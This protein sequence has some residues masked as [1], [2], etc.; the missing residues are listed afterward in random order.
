MKRAALYIRVSTDE[1]A[2]HGYSLDEQ[3][4]TL[5]DYAAR[6]GYTIVDIYA[7]EGA[8]ARKALKNR[9]ELQRLLADVRAGLIDCILFIKLDRWFRNIRDFYTV[10]DILDQHG[11]K[12]IATQEDY[13]TTTSAGRLNLNIRLSIAQNESDQTGERIRFIFDGKRRRH[14]AIAGHVTFG[15]RVED[16]HYVIDEPQ[17][18][19]VRAAFLYYAT[20]QS[21]YATHKHINETYDQAFKVESIR[22]MLSNERYIGRFWG[23][24]DYAPAV[25]DFDLWEKV[26]KIRAIGRRAEVPRVP[27]EPYLFSGLLFCPVCGR[28]LAGLHPKNKKYYRCNYSAREHVCTFS[29][30]VFEPTVERYL[31]DN[32]EER[33]SRYTAY[34]EVLHNHTDQKAVHRRIT[35]AQSRLDR[36]KD[37]YVTGCIDRASYD[38]DFKVYQAELTKAKME[39]RP[40][41]QR[42]P[43]GLNNILQRGIQAI[44]SD[45]SMA[46]KKT[47]WKSIIHRL[48]I[49]RWTKGVHA[50]LEFNIIFL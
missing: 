47:F 8:T 14:E 4:H 48:E 20:C 42:I 19:I 37:L 34:M 16:K 31:L 13:N 40:R 15:Y 9:H 36:L 11:V 35:T 45:L 29:T 50:Q 17:A 3:R 46:G 25:I 6:N 12:W 30:S 38:K 49:T 21:I 10:Q 22:Y 24:D 41:V 26:Q 43:T 5:E 1:Q 33:V 28:R 39:S 2:R 32:I 18:A 7:D 44:Y 27:K 23:I